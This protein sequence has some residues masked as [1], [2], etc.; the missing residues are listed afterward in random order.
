MH[1]NKKVNPVSDC[2]NNGVRYELGETFSSPDEPCS[3]CV[4]QAGSVECQRKMC[5]V[6]NCGSPTYVPG[7]CC[8]VCS[9]KSLYH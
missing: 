4:C 6:P 9:G 7:G 2:E 8:P 5:G 1:L 3:D